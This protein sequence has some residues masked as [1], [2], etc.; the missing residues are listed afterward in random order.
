MWVGLHATGEVNLQNTVFDERGG[1]VAKKPKKVN[2]LRAGIHH[3][4]FLNSVLLGPSCV[5]YKV[6]DAR[7]SLLTLP[8]KYL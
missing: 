5:S 2:H 6:R 8:V 7:F 1:G 3:S 4:Y